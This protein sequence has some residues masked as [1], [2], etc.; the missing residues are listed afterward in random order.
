MTTTEPQ[1][2]PECKGAPEI[3]NTKPRHWFVACSKNSEHP[4]GHRVIGHPMF[5]KHEAIAEWNKLT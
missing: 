4:G 5:T 1:A 3:R 2:C